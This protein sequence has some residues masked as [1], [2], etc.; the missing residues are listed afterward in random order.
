MMQILK[1]QLLHNIDKNLID[2]LLKEYTDLLTGFY[3][4]DNE[5]ILS[6]IIGSKSFL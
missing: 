1:Q 2:E 6:C 3:I 5:K 4:K